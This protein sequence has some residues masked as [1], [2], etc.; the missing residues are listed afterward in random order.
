MEFGP[1]LWQA[2][3]AAAE[4][5]GLS[6][7]EYVRWVVEAKVAPERVVRL[8]EGGLEGAPPL[9]SVIS[10]EAGLG[11]IAYIRKLWR[12][13]ETGGVSAM[14]AMTPP[15]VRW[16]PSAADGQALHGTRQ[17]TDFW[18]GRD[19]R[20]PSVRM[21]HHLGDDVLVEAEYDDNGEPLRTVWLLFRFDGDRLLE[22]IAFPDEPQALGYGPAA[23]VG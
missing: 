16:H 13:F 6:A 3:S 8:A 23:A 9:A 15:D 5:A 19:L 14:A 17:L 2:V 12:A 4:R 21:F 18:D 1:D 20:V 10:L 7:D 11:N 22:A